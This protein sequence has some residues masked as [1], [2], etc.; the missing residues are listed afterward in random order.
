M[1]RCHNCGQ[2]LVEIDN[3][4][5]RLTGCITC[6][7]WTA[8]D[9][10]G[11]TRRGF[12]RKTYARCTSCGT[13]GTNRRPGAARPATCCCTPGLTSQVTGKA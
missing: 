10:K 12:L 7:L 13:A 9:A 2:E 5:Q 1:D 4:G 11:W 8:G 3:R 6:N